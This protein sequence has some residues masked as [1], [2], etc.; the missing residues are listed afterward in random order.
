MAALDCFGCFCLCW[1][2]LICVWLFGIVLVVCDWFDC[3]CIECVLTSLN[4][5]WLVLIGFDCFGCVWLLWIPSGLCLIVL[6]ASDCFECRWL[7]WLAFDC[8]ECCWLIPSDWLFLIGLGRVC[9]FSDCLWM[10]SLLSVVCI[11]VERF[12]LLLICPLQFLESHCD[13]L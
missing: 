8:L 10:C 5:V 7:R 2:S 9:L 1:L 12:R 11:I 3:A 13:W 6:I 4:Y